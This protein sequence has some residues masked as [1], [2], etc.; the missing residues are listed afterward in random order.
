MVSVKSK[1]FRAKKEAVRF[2]TA[3]FKCSLKTKQEVNETQGRCALH[4]NASVIFEP[5]RSSS[6]RPIS[7]TQLHT[8]LYFHT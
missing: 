5:F 3:S 4:C 6:P 2:R 8:L 1:E 7:I